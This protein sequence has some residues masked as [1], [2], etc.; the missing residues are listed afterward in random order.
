MRARFSEARSPHH[1]HP[2]LV[3]SI[4]ETGRYA[5][6][7]PRVLAL[8][9]VKGGYGTGAG[10]IAM[11][12]IFGK[13]VFHA[14]A[15]GIGLLYASRGLGALVGPFLV[16]VIAKTDEAQYR[17][18]T[19][20]VLVFALGYAGLGLAPTLMFGLVAIF[21]AHLGGGI[22]WQVS[23][24]GLQRESDDWIRGRV[25]SADYGILTLTMALSSLLAGVLSDR[26]GPSITTV[27]LAS[28][29]VVFSVVWG[30]ATWRL[31]GRA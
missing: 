1:E 7:H 4:R 5:K 8:L 6:T 23:S 30:L 20:A 15:M 10:V 2:P 3:E 29:C 14:G 12:S 11:L 9:V 13:E 25:F 31:W 26:I 18:I 17:A 16:R 19:F 27:G 24:Y 22:A 21:F 28:V